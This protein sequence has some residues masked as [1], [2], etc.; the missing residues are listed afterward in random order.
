[1]MVVW[2]R[3][4]WR[5]DGRSR[6]R[7]GRISPALVGVGIHGR[8]GGIGDDGGHGRVGEG[9][10]SGQGGRSSRQI[11]GVSQDASGLVS[12]AATAAATVGTKGKT[13]N[14]RRGRGR[15]RDETEERGRGQDEA[16]A[17]RAG[18]KRQHGRGEGRTGWIS[19]L[20]GCEDATRV[21]GVRGVSSQGVRAC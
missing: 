6:G 13:P 8:D 14:T 15:G 2:Q 7:N 16:D 4:L 12:T 3:G 19:W 5:R 11:V 18:N 9:S 20:R 10:W 17:A 1:M 21:E